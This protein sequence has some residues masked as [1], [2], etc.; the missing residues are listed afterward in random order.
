MKAND[1]SAFKFWPE[2]YGRYKVT[3]TTPLRGD[4]FVAHISDMT[5]ID[6]TLH[7]EHAKAAD[8]EHLARVVRATGR[9]YTCNGKLIS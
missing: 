3:Y 2:P 8:I 4:Y 6:A 9:H 1:L 7:A 5:I